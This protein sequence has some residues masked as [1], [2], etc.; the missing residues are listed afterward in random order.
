MDPKLSQ[1]GPYQIEAE[2]GRGD[3]AVVYR[4]HDLLYDRAV[5]LKVLQSHLAQ[6]VAFV[7]RFVSAGREA[8][9]LRHPNILTVYEAGQSAHLHCD[10][11]GSG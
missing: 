3:V 5:A 10:G 1:I 6:D 9:R 8:I 7:R 11:V 4:A 2:I